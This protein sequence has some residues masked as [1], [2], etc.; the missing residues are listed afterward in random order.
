MIPK[1]LVRLIENQPGNIH[2]TDKGMAIVALETLGVS[3]GCEF[4]SIYINYLPA[5]FQSSVSDEYI[6]DVSEPTEQILIGTEFIHGMW[7]LPK[8]YIDFTSSQ[9]EGGYLLDKISG[10]VLDF[11]LEQQK[12]FVSGLIS[13]KWNSF[14]EIIRWYLPPAE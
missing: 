5:N 4:D 3:P 6:C 12:D 8:N 14:F 13:P 11:G 2:R 9:S 7:E 10:G 1:D